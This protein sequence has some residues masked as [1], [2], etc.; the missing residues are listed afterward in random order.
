MTA[1]GWL[2]LV[3]VCGFV[4]GGALTLVIMAMRKEGRKRAGSESP[5]S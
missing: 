4:W 2:T 3:I 5:G 1:A